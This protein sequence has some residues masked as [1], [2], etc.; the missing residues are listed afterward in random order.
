MI[1]AYQISGP[2]ASLFAWQVGGTS[3]QVKNGAVSSAEKYRSLFLREHGIE[4][5]IEEATEQARRFLMMARVILQPMP[6]RFLPRY[7]QLLAKQ[8]KPPCQDE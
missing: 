8:Q 6:K 4:L 1:T 7:Q 5:T 3:F 2:T